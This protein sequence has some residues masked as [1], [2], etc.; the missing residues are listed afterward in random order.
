MQR[1][2]VSFYHPNDEDGRDY[3]DSLYM[4][5]PIPRVGEWVWCSDELIRPVERVIWDMYPP[6]EL[7]E[8][9]IVR[10]YLGWP[11]HE[12]GPDS[13]YLKIARLYPLTCSALAGIVLFMRDARSDPNAKRS[14][15]SEYFRR[16]IQ[17][18][19]RRTRRIRYHRRR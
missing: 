3:F 17:R 1:I 19:H 4:Y 8:S 18:T 11:I 15:R 10:V 9:P 5:T 16:G 7:G 2:A 13:P 6:V 12:D 14:K